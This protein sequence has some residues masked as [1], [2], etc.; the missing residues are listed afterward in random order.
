MYTHLKLSIRS[1]FP[2]DRIPCQ[3]ILFYFTWGWGKASNI[4][5]KWKI[6]APPPKRKSRKTHTEWSTAP[7]LTPGDF[8][9]WYHLI[10]ALSVSRCREIIE[11][12]AKLKQEN[13]LVSRVCSELQVLAYVCAPG[14]GWALITDQCTLAKRPLPWPNL[15]TEPQA[16]IEWIVP[17]I[18]HQN[19]KVRL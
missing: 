3:N 1:G 17:W 9:R 18:L 11:N 4:L 8:Q 12:K 19:E 5:N 2:P 14:P 10:L 15:L 16:I 7:P 6:N 13:V